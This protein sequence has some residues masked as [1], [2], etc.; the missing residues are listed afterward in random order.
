MPVELFRP[1]RASGFM[2]SGTGL[3][4]GHVWSKTRSLGQML[5]K[6]CVGFRGHIFKI[7]EIYSENLYNIV[8]VLQKHVTT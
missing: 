2:K 6:P 1:S 4:M 3:K 8:G 5:E 7:Q